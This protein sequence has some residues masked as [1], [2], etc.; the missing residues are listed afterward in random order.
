MEA[1]KKEIRRAEGYITAAMDILGHR[2]EKMMVTDQKI[3]ERITHELRVLG[4]EEEKEKNDIG[5]V[6]HINTEQFER[7]L[8]P[9]TTKIYDQKPG[10]RVYNAYEKT[11]GLLGRIERLLREESIERDLSELE[12][13]VHEEAKKVG[14]L[15]EMARHYNQRF[16][17]K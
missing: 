9:F 15:K 6:H 1:R 13:K 8:Y 16:F 7:V 3:S 4:I 14:T 11:I 2:N 10:E 5:W 17:S 12:L